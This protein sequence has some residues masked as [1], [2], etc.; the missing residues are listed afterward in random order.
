[1]PDIYIP[2][3][4]S[5]LFKLIPEGEDIIYSTLCEVKLFLGT[6]KHTWKSHVL[7]TPNYVA[8]THPELKMFKYSPLN[9]MIDGA[10]KLII[11]ELGL[12]EQLKI[13]TFICVI[14]N[15][16]LEREPNHESKEI[17]KNRKKTFQSTILPYLIPAKKKILSFI[18]S[19][20]NQQKYDRLFG[21]RLNR[22]LPKLE[23]LL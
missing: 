8:F 6:Y 13:D 16:K 19:D 7:I 12:I 9:S 4:Y 17:F 22:E 15:F 1:M 2:I 23:K 20:P 11:V 10:L 21:K 18:Q 5:N 14:F 3:N